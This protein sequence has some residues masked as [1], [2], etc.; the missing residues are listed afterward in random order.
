MKFSA[1][2][3]EG[4]EIYLG[5]PIS[6]KSRNI[7]R[8]IMRLSLITA[9]LISS[10]FQV[11]CASETKA[12]GAAEVKLTMELKNESILSAIKK[13]EQ[14]T[15]F[16]FIYRSSDIKDVQRINLPLEQRSLAETLNLILKG[17]GLSYS[18]INQKIL[19]AKNVP[20]AAAAEPMDTRVTGMV[21]D[22][23]GL[24]LPGVTIMVKGDRGSSTATDLNGHFNINIPSDGN[25]ILVFSYI[26]FKTQEVAVGTSASL[27]VTM[28]AAP[29][30]LKEVVVLGY[31]EQ[32][33]ESITGSVATVTGAELRQS[34]AANI[35]NS[36]AG[37][38]PGLIAFQGS[39]QPG[40][41][42]SRLLIRGIS[43]SKNS[44]P[45]IVIDGIPQEAVNSNGQ[46]VNSDGSPVNAFLPHIDPSDIESISILKD[47]GTAA[48]YGARAANGVILIT[49]RR[50]DRGK[51]SLNYTFN[52]S[53]QKPTRLAELVD[54]YEYATLLNEMYK[55]ENNFLPSANRG[56]T[57]EQLEV[58]RTGSDPD[59]YANTDWYSA[60]MKP[61]AFQ[62][63]HNISV[64]GGGDKSKYFISTGYLDQKGLYESAGF[65]QYSLRTNLDA[66]ISKNLKVSLNLNGRVEKTKDQ[67]AGGGIT[68]QYRTISP[69]LP[70]QFSNGT[71]NYIS[72]VS[73]NSSL[74][75]GSPYLMGR[76]DAG[77]VNTDL[78]ALESVGSLIYNVPFIT[79][80]TAKGTFSYNKYQ[81]YIKN[82]T[83]PYV[84]SVRNDNGT[85]TTRAT[86]NTRASLTEQFQ[87]RQTV[88][89]EASLNYKKTI[90]KHNIDVLALY[91]QTENQGNRILASRGNFASPQVDQ[92]FAGDVNNDDA[93][94]VGF[95]N[96]RQS[97]VGRAAYNYNSKYLLEFSFR[98][99]G[100]D[101]FPKND[102]FGFFPA[103]SAGWILSEES[104]LK[105]ISVINFLKLRGSYGQLGNDRIGQFDY[106]NSYTLG[107]GLDGYYIFGSSEVQA[108]VPGVIPNAT[109]TWEKA[110]IGNIG[111]EARLFNNK[112]GIEADYFYKR[113]KDILGTR[114]FVI[115]ATIGASTTGLPQENLNVIDNSGFEL[116]LDFK[117]RI[118]AVDYFIKPNITF[119]KN[120]VIYMPEAA[121]TLPYQSLIGHPYYLPA[122]NLTSAA[123]Y[124]ADGLYQSAA[125]VAAGPT[126]LYTT[127][128]A[129][130]I[131]Y[132]DIN[133][134]GKIT[135]AD[136]TIISKGDYPQ[137]M[138]GL[139]MGVN[140]K[141]FDISV[142]LQGAAQVE[143][144]MNG[145]GEW[146]FAGNAVPSKKHL[147]RWTP[148]NTAAS[149]PR[150][151][152]SYSNN[153]EISSYWLRNGSYFRLK[154]LEL[155]Y[156]VPTSFL[157]KI[158]VSNARFYVSGTNL[159]TITSLKDVDP[160]ALVSS[161]GAE[162][163]MIQK[164]FNLGLTV[165]F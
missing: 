45:L 72:I 87:Q 151:F 81:T 7:I 34:P 64:N 27:K 10:T 85:Y 66:E 109:F 78:N 99:D 141:G 8:Q 97:L 131:K 127:V 16:R 107:S 119:N 74:I 146:A 92:L 43:T 149:Y 121:G 50:G 84:T 83:K 104:F 147:D 105:D 129:G 106:L 101:V 13:I 40:R 6:N 150:L 32:K 136:K 130:D 20:P 117:D 75:N 55:N 139:S 31:S 116:A 163:Y 95:R 28:N 46:T 22:Q 19:V 153:K 71:Y 33:K 124:I 4:S 152:S 67:V 49:T 57:N 155:G 24:P 93:T 44:S 68:S 3:A 137:I 165:K 26:G 110:N 156:N 79:G 15:S 157:S 138:Y 164:V 11:L 122:V 133:G 135:T 86:G 1:K 159:F 30:S 118:G 89:A 39:G 56:Y 91:T 161:F 132:R 80:L 25:Q 53:W 111:F 17:N 21:A 2:P 9:I 102:R 100:S 58:I 145:L 18:E 48:V 14:Q 60:L 103:V 134:D 88:L 77:Y 98:Y 113:T 23:D 62:Q 5:F 47:A 114:A 52:G 90:N 36:L 82:F 70:S 143:K 142:L 38:L 162:S 35:S 158:N 41:D 154:N 37:R 76:G 148:E 112:L 51:P 73:G 42:D 12:Q 123:G 29:G 160:E 65:K 108:L 96:A 59:R 140:Y 94:G 144:Y 54:S 126:P 69:L 61:S 125:E 63:R 115:P 128:A 120:K